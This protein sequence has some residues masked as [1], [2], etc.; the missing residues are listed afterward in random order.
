MPWWLNTM[1]SFTG[2]IVIGYTIRFFQESIEKR[3]GSI[4][5][6]QTLKTFVTL[7]VTIVWAISVIASLISNQEISYL[8]SG[9]MGGVVGYLYQKKENAQPK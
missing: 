5:S 7:V 9:I 4:Y 3:L 1:L 2:G 6:T 8:T